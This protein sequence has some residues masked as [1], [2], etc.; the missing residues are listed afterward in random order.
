M[1]RQDVAPYSAVNP[2][3]SLDA[4]CGKVYELNGKKFELTNAALL[5]V[6]RAGYPIEEM[7]KHIAEVVPIAS[8]ALL[9]PDEGIRLLG[10]S[11]QTIRM[12]CGKFAVQKLSIDD[13]GVMTGIFLECVE[14]FNRAFTNFQQKAT[15][16]ASG[17]VVAS[18]GISSQ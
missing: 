12:T 18:A 10:E 16:G 11:P 6:A 2:Q 8:L 7:G 9:E 14:R 13:M 15:G 3:D 17:N 5:L 4:L 1:T